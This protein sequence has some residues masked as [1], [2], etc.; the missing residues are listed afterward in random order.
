MGSSVSSHLTNHGARQISGCVSAFTGLTVVATVLRFFFS[1]VASS[2]SSHFTN[3]GDCV[4]RSS[5]SFHLTNY[6]ECGGVSGTLGFGESSPRLAFS[7]QRQNPSQVDQ[8]RFQP[9]RFASV[10][11]LRRAWTCYARG[12]NHCS[13]LLEDQALFH[14]RLASG[15]GSR[16]RF[17]VA[18]SSTSFQAT[19][20]EEPGVSD[21]FSITFHGANH[22]DVFGGFPVAPHLTNQGDCAGVAEG[23]E[24]S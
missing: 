16:S 1:A 22:G 3:Q 18:A 10:G 17:A 7:P 11:G 9:S 6:G 5:P 2:T 14:S 19:N 24:E 21:F 23:T 4:G 20:H 8:A 13:N 15:A 12:N